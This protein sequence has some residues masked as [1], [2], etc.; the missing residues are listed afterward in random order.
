MG[1]FLV[2]YAEAGDRDAREAHRAE[3]IRYRKG[4]GDR[5]ALAGSLLDAEGGPDGSVVIL[6]ADDLEVATEIANGD[7]YVALGVLTLRSV[8]P[9]R[10]AAMKPPK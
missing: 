6:E 7:P 4:L 1:H 8:R 5:L 2:E 9:Y 10:I 3:H